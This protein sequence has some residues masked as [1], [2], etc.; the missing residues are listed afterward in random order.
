MKHQH[1]RAEERKHQH[2][3]SPEANPAV[4]HLIQMI[5]LLRDECALRTGP[6]SSAPGLDLRPVFTALRN[7][8]EKNDSR[9]A[10]LVYRREQVLEMTGWSR[11]TLWRRCKS[12]GISLGRDVFTPE[13]IIMIVRRKRDSALC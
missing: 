5:R 1:P 2:Q 12:V 11:T 13:E 4:A 10:P 3:D 9:P 7:V 6:E 8:E